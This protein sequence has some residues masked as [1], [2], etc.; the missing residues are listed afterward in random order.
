MEGL[1]QAAANRPDC[2]LGSVTGV[3]LP[4]N[5]L[6]VFLDRLDADAQAATNFT[7][8]ETQGDVSQDLPFAIGEWALV[9]VRAILPPR[10]GLFEFLQQAG[11]RRLFTPGSTEDGGGELV[12]VGT[13]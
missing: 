2:G 3:H 4:Q 7:V 8:A 12:A 6:H 1:D 11:F 5:V 13:F 9:R 10:H